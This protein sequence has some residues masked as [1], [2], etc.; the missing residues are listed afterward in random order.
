MKK[1][2]KISKTMWDRKFSFEDISKTDVLKRT[3]KNLAFKS[4]CWT[5]LSVAEIL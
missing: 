3:R 5:I 1:A 2:I 4:L